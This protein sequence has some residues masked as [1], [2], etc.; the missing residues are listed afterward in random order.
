MARRSGR[1]PMSGVSVWLPGTPYRA[2]SDA[3]GGVEIR[4]LVSGPY[5]LVI[6][7]STLLAIDLNVPTT[8]GFTA[9]RDSV[10]E[11]S[12]RA[13]TAEEYVVD[14]C[15]ADRRFTYSAAD[16]TRLIARVMDDRGKPV[17]GVDW[18]AWVN[19]D[20]SNDPL[21]VKSQWVLVR[22]GGRRK[23]SALMVRG[24]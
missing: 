16:S 24:G 6:I 21:H 5:T 19:A 22:E 20:V 1:A 23:V 18:T 4:D 2:M 8:V 13:R 3:N 15:I 10:I 9:D 11:Q 17:D 7:D 12:F 14:R